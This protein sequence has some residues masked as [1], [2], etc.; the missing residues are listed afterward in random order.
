MGQ[1]HVQGQRC[2]SRNSRGQSSRCKGSE[3]KVSPA[4]SRNTKENSVA[5]AGLS[6]RGSHLTGSHVGL[7]AAFEPHMAPH[8]LG[9]CPTLC[10]AL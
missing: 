7:E 9:P 6:G 2:T 3:E 1:P 10:P 4:N 8:G 5:K